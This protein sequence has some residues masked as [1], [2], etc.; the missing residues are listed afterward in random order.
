[1]EKEE[2]KHNHKKI[3]TLGLTSKGGQKL[4]IKKLEI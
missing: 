3:Y 2:I 1:M 4:R